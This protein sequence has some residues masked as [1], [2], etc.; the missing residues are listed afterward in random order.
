MLLGE[1]GINIATFNLGRTASGG[2]A[3]ALVGVD[4]TPISD[5]TTMLNHIAQLKPGSTSKLSIVRG[6]QELALLVKIGRRPKVPQA[7]DN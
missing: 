3:I 2:D 1:A 4:Q 7:Q 5:T 6:S